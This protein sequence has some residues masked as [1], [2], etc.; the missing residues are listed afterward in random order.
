MYTIVGMAARQQR[1]SLHLDLSDLLV[2]GS[3]G[4]FDVS[5]IAPFPD[6][7]RGLRKQLLDE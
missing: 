1:A 5:I 6:P 7:R 2:V 3:S 4:N